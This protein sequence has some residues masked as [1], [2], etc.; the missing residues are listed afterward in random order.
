MEEIVSKAA[1][2]AVSNADLERFMYAEIATEA[3]GMPLSV[4]SALSREG[5]DPWQEAQQLAQLPRPAA[6]D[7]LAGL[8]NRLPL[9]RSSR[10]DAGQVASR[11][12]A[13]LPSMSFAEARIVKAAA[14]A[15]VIAAPRWMFLGMVA[16]VVA[17]L[18]MPAMAPKNTDTVAPASWFN[19]PAQQTSPAAAAHPGDAPVAAHEGQAA[20]TTPTPPAV[21]TAK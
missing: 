20:P 4:L 15:K 5:V 6:A 7:R 3:N 16:A 11:L 12:V 10:I 21:S 2:P 13:L 8:L 19:T 1:T 18:L 9:F 14:D 17:G